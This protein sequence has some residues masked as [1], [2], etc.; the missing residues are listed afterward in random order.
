MTTPV[1]AWGITF[2]SLKVVKGIKL[3]K[4]IKMVRVECKVTIPQDL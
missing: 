1:E 2:T 4:G 3:V